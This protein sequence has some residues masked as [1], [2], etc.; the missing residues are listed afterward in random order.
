MSFYKKA[1]WFFKR[2]RGHKKIQRQY[3]EREAIEKQLSE[4]AQEG[5]SLTRIIKE[6]ER[7]LYII[8]NE[9]SKLFWKREY[10]I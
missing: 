8:R 2:R 9:H 6:S 5:A 10:L 1:L 4:L 3:L 7:K